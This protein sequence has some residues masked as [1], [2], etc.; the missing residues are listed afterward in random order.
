MVAV[1]GGRVGES[2]MT[3]VCVTAF[4]VCAGLGCVVA[5]V[6][7]QSDTAVVRTPHGDPD[8]QGVFT[9]RTLTP[10]QRPVID[11]GASAALAGREF[12]TDE[13][14]VLLQQRAAALFDGETDAAFGDS[15]CTEQCRALG[16]RSR[17]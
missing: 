9:F 10:L 6:A 7:A 15:Q 1:R 11:A 14:V 3:R 4:I 5:P 17:C 2:Q 12:L 13:E 8:I 16:G